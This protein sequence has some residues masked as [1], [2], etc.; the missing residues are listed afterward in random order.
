V[1]LLQQRLGI[2]ADGQFGPGTRTAVLTFQRSR[3]L[4]ADGIVGPN[5][6][7]KLFATQQA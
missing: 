1:R 3:G 7:A 2:A 5:T 6:W 4:T